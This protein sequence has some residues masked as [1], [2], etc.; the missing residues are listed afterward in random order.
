MMVV[1]VGMLSKPE[2]GS[3][4]NMEQIRYPDGSRADEREASRMTLSFGLTAGWMVAIIWDR[5]C[6]EQR[7]F[8]GRTNF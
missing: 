7:R 2:I 4:L 5:K 6:C 3:F 8:W 1:A